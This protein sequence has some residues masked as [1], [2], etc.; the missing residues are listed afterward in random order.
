MA[1]TIE[2]HVCKLETEFKR[3]TNIGDQLGTIHDN[4]NL[5]R[6]LD[7]SRN[8]FIGCYN[9]IKECFKDVIINEGNIKLQ[10]LYINLK[11]DYD[12][13]DIVLKKKEREFQISAE[14]EDRE[15]NQ[16]SARSIQF[17]EQKLR[18]YNTN[19]LKI[20]EDIQREKLIN[21]GEI[22]SDLRDLQTTYVQFKDL[23]QDQDK[24]IKA[25][26][27][28]THTTS[29]KI[30]SGIVELKSASTHQKSS[31][32]RLCCLVIVVIAIIAIIIIV[33]VVVKK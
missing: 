18:Q 27:N 7:K 20:E 10:N 14:K 4:A 16:S 32:K 2:Y 8:E 25:I 9:K 33:V 15:S 30:E 26:Q 5:R 6:K 19:D 22:E 3:I 29:V 24:G 1:N 11:K 28:N 17:R 12:A 21:A 23:V 13:L 31:R